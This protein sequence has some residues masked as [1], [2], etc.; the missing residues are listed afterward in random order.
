MEY[1]RCD[2]C[3]R[4]ECRTGE[5]P[6]N[7]LCPLSKEKI[8]TREIVSMYRGEE[9]D[10]YRVGAKIEAESYREI[11]GAIT[12]IRPRLAEVIAFCRE[13]DIDRVGVAFC[14]GLVWEAGRVCKVL[15]DKGLDV[16]SVM[17]KCFSV[18]KADLGVP[19]EHYIRQGEEKGCNPLMQARL[20]NQVGTQLN[21]IVGLCV[22]H[23]ILFTRH[24]QAPVTTLIVKDR[25]SGHNPMP[26]LYSAYFQEILDRE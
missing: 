10:L 25:M 13:M 14:A 18:E 24:S 11:D 12:P 1:P 19:E 7:P 17:C 15:D 8:E 23:D 4:K 26:P 5:P 16:A 6:T 21:L 3:G 9:G 2:R 22:G 20:L